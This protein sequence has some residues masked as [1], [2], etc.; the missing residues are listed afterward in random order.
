[1]QTPS[2]KI[3]FDKAGFYFVALVIIALLG[4]WQRYFSELVAGTSDHAFTFHFHAV[5]VSL[6]LTLLIV[7]PILIRK[8]KFSIHRAVGRSSYVVMPLLI[9]SVLMIQHYEGSVYP[10]WGLNFL[11]IMNG[12]GII[13]LVVFYAIAIAYRRNTRIHARAMIATGIFM[14][15][16]AYHRF[17][18]Y[19]LELD[20]SKLFLVSQTSMTLLL[21]TLIFMERKQTGGRWV[22]PLALCMYWIF[23]L[24]GNQRI[25]FVDPAFGK[26]FIKLPLTSVPAIILRDLPIQ[27]NEMDL[28]TGEWRDPFNT[29]TQTYKKDNQLWARWK[30]MDT[31]DSSRMLY[32]G[33]GKFILEKYKQVPISFNFHAKDGKPE[34]FNLYH[35]FTGRMGHTRRVK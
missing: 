34:I 11:D 35:A 15:E 19:V 18:V 31:V 17:L 23:A 16:P 22:F 28:Y 12:G 6:W 30:Q 1:M 21:G 9:L 7:Q 2:S 10:D 8:K 25:P 13:E 24:L 3:A 14:I 5:M 33:N 20:L 29:T 27:Q 26:W 32:Q 4:F